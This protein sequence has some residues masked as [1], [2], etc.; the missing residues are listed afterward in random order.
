MDEYDAV[1]AEKLGSLLYTVADGSLSRIAACDNS[2][3]LCK[4]ELLHQ[5]IAVVYPAL[6]DNENNAV[7]VLVPLEM[8]YRIDKYGL[9]V[10]LKELLG[11]SL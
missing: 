5:L 6:K 8:L 2:P 10:E 7:N 11:F 1:L 9:A 4:A 3:D